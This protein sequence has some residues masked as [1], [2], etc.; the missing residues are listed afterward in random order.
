M[1]V[2]ST[3]SA[4]MFRKINDGGLVQN[5]IRGDTEK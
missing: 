3:G 4:A 1:E 2:G 5:Y